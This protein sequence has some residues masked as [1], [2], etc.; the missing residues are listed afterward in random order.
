MTD[1]LKGN[2]VCLAHPDERECDVMVRAFHLSQRIGQPV[3]TPSR[4]GFSLLMNAPK[5]TPQATDV[6][7]VVQADRPQRFWHRLIPRRRG[8]V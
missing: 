4:G 8:L 1:L 6:N 7:D 3:A 5:A 2:I